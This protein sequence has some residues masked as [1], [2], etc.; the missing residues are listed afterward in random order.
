MDNDLKQQRD[1][2]GE[3]S[4]QGMG[5]TRARIANAAKGAPNMLTHCMYVGILVGTVHMLQ[6]IQTNLY[7][8]SEQHNNQIITRY[9]VRVQY[10]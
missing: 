5:N 3:T 4:M 1:G 9:R 8:P 10:P 7:H 2:A 6:N